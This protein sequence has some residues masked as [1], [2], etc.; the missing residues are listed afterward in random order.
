MLNIPLL[1]KQSNT[2]CPKKS[3]L[4]NLKKEAF[5]TKSYCQGMKVIVISKS[6]RPRGPKPVEVVNFN[7]IYSSKE[8]EINS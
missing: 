3:I 1:Q 4:H 8:S 7:T 5:L 6:N 2:R